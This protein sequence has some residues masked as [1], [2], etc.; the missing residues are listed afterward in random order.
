MD[1]MKVNSPCLDNLSKL[2]KAPPI[3]IEFDH[4]LYEVD[5]YK[6]GKFL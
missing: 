4:L 2:P 6:Y 5:D 1:V 3:N